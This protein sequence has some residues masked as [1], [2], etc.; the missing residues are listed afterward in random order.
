MAK[1]S[2]IGGGK[3]GEALIAGLVHSGWS[4][5]DEILVCEIHEERRAYLG[6]EYGV[7]TTRDATD[8]VR[9]SKNVL[10]AVKPQDIDDVLSAMA[11]AVTPEHL[12]VS[13]AA[14]IPISLIQRH[15]GPGVPVVRAMPNTAALL[16]EGAAAI[17]GGA[18]ATAEHMAK[19]DEILSATCRIVHLPRSE[20]RRVGKECRSRW[21]PYH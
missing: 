14:G 10:V 8:A 19:A 7:G 12:V 4:A 16:R 11:A 9:Q 6:K 20:E 21:S 1:L 17:A 3:M 18:H 15:L 5:A 2:I 13:I